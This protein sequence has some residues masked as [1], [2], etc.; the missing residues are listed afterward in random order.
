MA[1]DPR[2]IVLHADNGGPMKGATMVATLEKLGVLASWSRPSVS[3]DNP[4]SEAL[5]RTIK[6]RPNYPHGPFEDVEAATSWLSAFVRWYNTTHLHSAIR[7]VTPD[8][9]HF[10]REKAILATRRRVYAQ[11]R[12]EHPE[13]WARG[14]RNWDQ[15]VVVTLNPPKTTAQKTENQSIRA[16]FPCFSDWLT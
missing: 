12:A 5:F 13:R 6:Y 15:V 3:D 9:R 10:G 7:F 11:A 1:I 16:E 14:T 4:Y 2:G 8:D